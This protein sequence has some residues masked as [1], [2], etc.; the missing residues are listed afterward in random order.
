MYPLKTQK[1]MPKF[2]DCDASVKRKSTKRVIFRFEP[3]DM[4]ADDQKIEI[5]TFWSDGVV[6]ADHQKNTLKKHGN[7]RFLA[8]SKIGLLIGRFVYFRG[9]KKIGFFVI[10]EKHTYR[11]SSFSEKSR[12][13]REFSPKIN[14]PSSPNSCTVKSP[15]R[16]RGAEELPNNKIAD[17]YFRI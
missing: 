6:K 10:L 12:K 8:F 11:S 16:K 5:W 17:F 9:S 7:S 2:P 4:K 3:S 1:F 13:K 15:D 14:E